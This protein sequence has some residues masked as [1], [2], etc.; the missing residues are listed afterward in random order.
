MPSDLQLPKVGD[1]LGKYRITRVLGQGGMGAV[2]EA[3][4]ARLGQRV[5]LKMLLPEFVDRPELLERFEREARAASRIRGPNVARVLDVETDAGVPYIVMELLE[6]HDVAHELEA[7]GGRLPVEDA[8]D[9]VIQACLGIAEAHQSGIIHRDLKPSNLFLVV[10]AGQRMVKIL[11]FGI[12][13]VV[14]GES[15]LTVTESSI[16]TPMYMSPEQIRSSKHVDVRT[17]VWALGIISYELLVGRPPFVGGA[18]AVA[19]AIVVDEAPPLRTFRVDVPAGLAEVVHRALA[20]APDQRFADARTLAAALLPFAGATTRA[21][22]E[23]ALGDVQL[24]T[25]KYG[26]GAPESHAP[27]LQQVDRPAWPRDE[28][29]TAVAPIAR[30]ATPEPGTPAPTDARRRRPWWLAPVALVAL[31]A[32]GGLM[33][34]ARGPDGLAS[35]SSAAATTASIAPSATSPPPATTPSATATAPS[36]TPPTTVTA[37]SSAPL[38]VASEPAPGVAAS[39]TS[40]GAA[41]P[42]KP[43]TK[44]SVAAT[45][46]PTVVAPTGNPIRL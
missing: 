41:P 38:A 29:E 10:E 7:R 12:S 25:A 22:V 2:F 26:Y 27:T 31:V 14:D 1:A 11:D 15:A 34:V 4:H 46:A 30:A 3:E 45:P 33:A 37:A 19:A 17:D 43:K 42:S 16:G 32:L 44:A 20:K 36:T 28:G 40:A 5:A 39:V 6:G 18:T 35:G 8:V 13:K 21:R 9:I 23:A 24:L